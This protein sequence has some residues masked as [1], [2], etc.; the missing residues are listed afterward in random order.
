[1]TTPTRERFVT[2][3][4]QLLRTQGYAGTGVQQIV[5]AAKAPFGSLY[6]HFPGGK[7]DLAAEAIRTSGAA[8]VALV[9]AIFD[10][11]PDLPTGVRAFFTAAAAHLV[12]TGYAD[13]CPIATVAL[14]VASTNE[15]LRQATA[16]VFDGWLDYGTAYFS[17]RGLP[18]RLARELTLALVTALEGA[19]VLDQATRRTDALA[20]AGELV[21]AWL[22]A[23]S[24]APSPPEESGSGSRASAG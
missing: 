10:P 19:F 21:S 18:A 15:T 5:A 17:G 7:V 6:H 3:T 16:D 8:Y 22:A 13:A 1:M 24:P 11:A 12:E 9:P 20:M 4:A 2:E 14:E 23:R